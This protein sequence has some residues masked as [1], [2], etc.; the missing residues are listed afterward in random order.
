MSFQADFR[1]YGYTGWAA[2]LPADSP[3]KTVLYHTRKTRQQIRQNVPVVWLICIFLLLFQLFN[4]FIILWG[5]EEV[6]NQNKLCIWIA[7]GRTL[8]QLLMGHNKLYICRD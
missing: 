4:H 1:L 3:L 2:R 8:A 7:V 5:S 6:C